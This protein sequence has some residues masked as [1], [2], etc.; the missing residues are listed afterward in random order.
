MYTAEF[1]KLVEEGL[2]RTRA[3]LGIKGTIYARG[4]RL[5][6]FKSAAQTWDKTPEHCLYGM[7]LKHWIKFTDM[8][9]DIDEFHG[10]P[11]IEQLE[12]TTGDIR[13]YMHLFEALVKERIQECEK[14]VINGNKT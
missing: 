11:S 2:D 4:D 12:E 14:E 1:L 7:V 6:N 10:L 5:S 9:A 13:A 8:V 3:T